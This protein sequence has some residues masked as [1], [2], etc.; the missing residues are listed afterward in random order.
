M[1][2]IVISHHSCNDDSEYLNSQLLHYC[3]LFFSPQR[4][5]K[6]T[7]GK[8]SAQLAQQCSCFS[9][10]MHAWIH[11]LN[12]DSSFSLCCTRTRVHEARKERWLV[13]RWSQ[14]ANK[15]KCG[16]KQRLVEM[17]VNGVDDRQDEAHGKGDI[18]GRWEV[19]T[20]KER[21][22]QMEKG[23][24]S[25][26]ESERSCCHPSLMLLIRYWPAVFVCWL[27]VSVWP[28]VTPLK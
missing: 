5:R 20:D 27:R 15:E 18:S 22:R 9:G 23:S 16:E 28:A 21:E 26:W 13:G 4:K 24:E 14:T 8:H 25:E 19:G 7:F 1:Y 11:I 2:S 3:G 6:C 12:T 17:D 10:R